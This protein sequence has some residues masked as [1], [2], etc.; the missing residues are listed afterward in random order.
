MILT[1]TDQHTKLLH[2]QF[3]IANLIQRLREF[4][5]KCYAIEKRE[6]KGIYILRLSFQIPVKFHRNFSKYESY[7]ITNYECFLNVIL[8][9][10]QHV[11]PSL[12]VHTLIFKKKSVEQRRVSYKSQQKMNFM[13]MSW[14]RIV[15]ECSGLHTYRIS[16][17]S[18]RGN[19]SFLESQVR[20]LFKGGNYSKE[21]TI[22]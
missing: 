22:N 9:S 14:F 20:Q 17:Y 15:Q 1:E 10:R 6:E 3:H 8:T 21:E 2:V 18:C 5:Y 7:Y 16:S 12:L 11:D 19:Y 13:R 4:N